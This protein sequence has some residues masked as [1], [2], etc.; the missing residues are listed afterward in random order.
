MATETPDEVIDPTATLEQAVDVVEQLSEYGSLLANSLYVLII[1]MAIIFVLHKLASIFL[2]SRIKNARLMRVIFGTLYVLVFVITALLVLRS[3]GFEVR[4]VGQLAL[5]GVLLGAVVT[6]FLVPFLPRLPF[7]LGHMVEIN[8]ALGIVD[9]ISTYHTTIRKFDGTVVFIPNALVMASKIMNFHDT[10]TRR[11]ELKLSV[12]PDSDLEYT[13]NLVVNLLS[14]DDRVLEEPAPPVVFIMSANAYSV[15]MKAYCWVLNENWL[16][17]RSDL[18]LKLMN[19]FGSDARISL[20]I[21]E[22][23]IV[24]S[25]QNSARG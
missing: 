11:I 18:W 4:A 2:Y 10:P 14:E 24:V 12:T 9:A 17:G 22:Q 20:A 25:E 13:K 3:M 5:I 15:D 21:P 19:A 16:G 7:L 23:K 6:F 8:G 1:G